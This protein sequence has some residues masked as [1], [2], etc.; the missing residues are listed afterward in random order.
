M[1]LVIIYHD[2]ENTLINAMALFD[3]IKDIIAWSHGILKY[4][5]VQKTE[6]KY[7]TYK[8]VFRIIEVHKK[9]EMRYFPKFKKFKKTL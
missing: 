9:N 3:K 7:R 8:S 1:Y 2:F 5:D 4:N 6:R